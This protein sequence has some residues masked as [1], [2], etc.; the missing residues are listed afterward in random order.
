MERCGVHGWT[1]S[2]RAS[3]GKHAVPIPRPAQ[4][5]RTRRQNEPGDTEQGMRLGSQSNLQQGGGGRRLCFLLF[6]GA[7]TF[8]LQRRCFTPSLSGLFEAV[9]GSNRKPR[10]RHRGHWH[11]GGLPVPTRPELA[12]SLCCTL[13]V[14]PGAECGKNFSVIGQAPEKAATKSCPAGWHLEQESSWKSLY[15]LGRLQ[16]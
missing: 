13:P 7:E 9:Y 4:L 16:E 10:P 12:R 2:S 5:R 1:T 6:D 3:P 14:V 11:G 8:C 15:R